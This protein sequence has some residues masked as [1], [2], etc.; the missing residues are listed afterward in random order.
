MSDDLVFSDE[1]TEPSLRKVSTPWQVMVVDDEPAVHEVTKLVM[2][3]FEMDGRTLAFIHCYSAAEARQVLAQPNEIALIL[4][5]VVMETEHAGLELARHIREDIGNLNVRIVLRTGQPGQAPEEQVIK[6]YDINDYKEKTDLTRRKLITVFYAGL[7]AYRDLMRIEQARQGLKRSI[8]AISQVCDSQN[9]RGFAS[10]VLEQ[11]NFLLGLNGEGLCAS[12]MSAYTANAAN[13][14]I[15]VLAATE[16]FSELLVDDEMGNLPQDV[17]DALKRTLKEKVGHHGDLHYAGYFRTKAGSESMI[18]MVFPEPIKDSA[19]E[20]L[21]MFSSNVAITYDSLL[22]RESTEVAQRDTISILGSA[23]ERR[24][25]RP[26]LHLQRIGDIAALLLEQ[27]G[28]SEREVAL[29]RV[30]ATLHDVGKAC[31]PDHILTKPGPLTAEEWTVMQTH[32]QEG[33][34]LLSPSKS[35]LHVLGAVIA[36]EHHEH[37]DGSG[38][39][40]GLSGEKISL[41]GRIVAV[42]DVLDSLVCESCYKKA[43]PLAESLAYL[44]AQSGQQFDPTLIALLNT[45]L[46][47]VHRIYGA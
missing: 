20:L 40:R 25:S 15:R 3:G 41:A 45:Q 18:Y 8:E 44:N 22:L 38:Y 13:G 4:L 5:D 32:A 21:E 34:A 1:Q 29:M 16:A 2:A 42:A 30:A 47:A 36:R 28:G 24:N 35:E 37:W 33:F 11:V 17:Q 10:A 7:R 43:W 46:P 31:V 39:P 14:R 19:R 23:I 9:L 12:R 27:T 6:D 26:S